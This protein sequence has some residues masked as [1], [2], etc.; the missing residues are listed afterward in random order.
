M[1]NSN[2]TFI[3]LL[4]E[5]TCTAISQ[6]F[7]KEFKPTEYLQEESL[8][9]FSSELIVQIG[10]RNPQYE[11]NLYWGLNQTSVKNLLAAVLTMA[12]NQQEETELAHSSLGELANTSACDLANRTATIDLLGKVLPTHPLIW[13]IEN[14]R[15]Q[16]F[17]G[18]GVSSKIMLDSRVEI[19][20]HFSIRPQ[21][22]SQG[23]IN[24]WRPTRSLAICDP[25]QK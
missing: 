11:I 17:Q 2:T 14:E 13:K 3:N 25:H 18:S 19:Y 15:P 16:F 20:T 23:D 22:K 24:S 12:G 8:P 10:L 9:S 4:N 6:L 7:Q 5:I 1:E 21:S